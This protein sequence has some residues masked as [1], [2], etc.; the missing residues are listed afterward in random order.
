MEENVAKIQSLASKSSRLI[1][2][3]FDNFLPFS[4]GKCAFLGP[5]C[6]WLAQK[7]DRVLLY[8]EPSPGYLMYVER[9]L[10]FKVPVYAPEKINGDGKLIASLLEDRTLLRELRALPVRLKLD[11][12]IQCIDSLELGDHLDMQHWYSTDDVLIRTKVVDDLNDKMEF[13]RAC[14]GLK[15]P[16]NRSIHCRSFEEII[17]AL[18]LN[19]NAGEQSV[20]VKATRSAGGIRNVTITHDEFVG[21]EA[22]WTASTPISSWGQEVL[23][24]PV[25]SAREHFSILGS[26]SRDGHVTIENSALRHVVD[27]ESQGATVPITQVPRDVFMLARKQVQLFATRFLMARGY[28]GPFDVD[29]SYDE[30]RGGATLCFW[31]TNARHFATEVQIQIGKHLGLPVTRSNE[32]VMV[33]DG[34]SLQEVCV[35]AK[36]VEKTKRKLRVII[37]LPP[38]KGAKSIG[39]CV[40]GVSHL[41]VQQAHDEM[42]RLCA[43][44]EQARS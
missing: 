36:D 18:T 38:R 13:H 30:K 34:I 40:C 39:I 28:Q 35:M 7:G 3:N 2:A 17:S 4:H 19:F 41:A 23:V 15:I 16:V 33:P 10:G 1:V 26:I 37:T 20:I 25:L 42:V 5:R 14:R 32:V 31:E 12:L 11:P 21:K 22:S 43:S 9:V 27:F 24:E 8:E 44:L 6:L 29:I